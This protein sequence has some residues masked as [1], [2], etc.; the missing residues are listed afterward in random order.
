M[1]KWRTICVKNG[2]YIEM[3]LS[4]FAKQPSHDGQ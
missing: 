3:N 2:A 1:I 4:P